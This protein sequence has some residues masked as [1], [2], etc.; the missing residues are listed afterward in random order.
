MRV[1]VVGAGLGGLCLAQGLRR[2]GIDVVVY[3]RDFGLD[4]R[5]QGYRLH[6]DGR[7]AQ[8][9]QACLPPELYDLFL[10][11]A[12]SPSRQVTVVTKQLKPLH[13]V[14]FPE[15][16]MSVPARVNTSVDRFVLRTILLA[17]LEDL[18][19]FGKTFVRY[20]QDDKDPAGG[21]RAF[22][23]DGTQDVAD[24]LVGAD[25]V[26]SRV[27]G[28]Y[29]PLARVRDTGDRVLY[30]KTPLSDER[31]ARLPGMLWDGFAAVVGSR[32]LGM[33]L[34][35]V[36]FQE[37]PADAAA[38]L[39][40]AADFE[41]ADSYVMWALSGKGSAFPADGRMR[42]LDGSGLRAIAED[43]VSGWHPH[44]RQLVVGAA[45]EETFFVGIRTSDPVGPWPTTTV[46]LLGD[47]IHAMPPSR[48]SG[49]NIALKDAG[50]LCAE[51]TR[52]AEG[53]QE[54]LE[55]IGRYESDMIDYGFT[56]VRD[57]L[58]VARQGGGPVATAA[59]LLSRLTGRRTA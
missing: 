3:E 50:R 28:Q 4:A 52:V 23:E 8:G 26:G 6:I 42:A 54:L 29:L 27:R 14:E 55:G 37:R 57:S 35:L 9:L 30:G 21:V 45:P 47:A 7:A 19:R 33:A 56:A 44:L 16:D 59:S 49:A 40:P 20:E 1:A 22:F 11:T 2:A 38:R 12:S 39:W 10:A 48:G 32:K 46:T 25:G 43:L 34:G 17:G 13:R 51:L 31:A 58:A 36:R 5:Q 18:V 15:P 53:G 24:V 41:G